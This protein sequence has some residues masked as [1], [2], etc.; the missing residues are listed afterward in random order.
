MALT[1]S[2]YHPDWNK[3][4]TRGMFA[5]MKPRHVD[6]LQFDKKVAFWSQCISRFCETSKSC[7]IDFTELRQRFRREDLIAAPLESVMI[8]MYKKGDLQTEE[9]LLKKSQGW[10]SWV[11]SLVTGGNAP[12]VKTQ[13][14][15]HL[16][17]IAK[18]AVQ[19]RNYHKELAE[20]Y[21]DTPEIISYR[22]LRNKTQHIIK[23]ELSFDLVINHLKK[24]G[25]MSEGNSKG[26]RILKFKDQQSRSPGK[27]TA[28]DA[29]VHDIRS[30]MRNLETEIRRLEEKEK[31]LKESAKQ[32]LQS[33]NRMKAKNII[34][35]KK[36]IEKEM[37]KKDGQ[38]QQLLNMLTKISETRQTAEVLDAYRLGNQAFKDALGRQ[39]LSVDT[40]DKT[41]DS[42][43]ETMDDFKEIN[44]AISTGFVPAEQRINDAELED[45][46]NEMLEA[47]Q[48]ADRNNSVK[49]N[50]NIINISSLPEVPTFGLP[51]TS[52]ASSLDSLSESLEYR[53]KRLRE[54]A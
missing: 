46:L 30:A 40:I 16:P 22:E 31:Q 41:I 34:L 54:Q 9:D 26:E 48:I 24:C 33:K 15:I 19:L 13:S 3:N 18:L 39:G 2:P 43:H 12:D 44:E 6:P 29:S 42:I 1:S 53:M 8:E 14:L 50:K 11:S 7:V 5:Y 36:L 38:Y 51:S 23:D 20:E 4:E 52:N 32:A 10:V 49:I 37:E 25:D 27:F 47:D 45:E 17:T 35:K 21:D 28:A